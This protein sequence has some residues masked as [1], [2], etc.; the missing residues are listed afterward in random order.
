MKLFHNSHCGFTWPGASSSRTSWTAWTGSSRAGGCRRAMAAVYRASPW[1]R[2]RSPVAPGP[3]CTSRP[4]GRR[5]WGGGGKTLG[6]P[7]GLTGSTGSASSSSTPW[8]V[9]VSARDREFAT[10][11]WL[12][13]MKMIEGI[14]KFFNW[15]DGKSKLIKLTKQMPKHSTLYFSLSFWLHW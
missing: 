9:C 1:S 14:A 5:R 8:S 10:L 4:G 7:Y 15:F 2:W 11:Q 6:S 3:W 13:N 12:L